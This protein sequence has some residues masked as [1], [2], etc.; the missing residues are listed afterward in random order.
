MSRVNNDNIH[1]SLEAVFGDKNIH[2]LLGVVRENMG[3]FLLNMCSILQNNSWNNILK[4]VMGCC[5]FTLTKALK[6]MGT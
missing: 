6:Q 2:S 1:Q 5:T 4:C 3:D